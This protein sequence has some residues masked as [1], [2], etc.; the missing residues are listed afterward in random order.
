MPRSIDDDRD[1]LERAREVASGLR[2]TSNLIETLLR[3][4]RENTVS[5]ASLRAELAG[6][7]DNLKV[8]S[9]LVRDSDGQSLM[10]RL[11]L[12]ES[13]SHRRDADDSTSKQNT[14]AIVLAV[15]SGLISL[16]VTMFEVYSK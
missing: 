8:I 5:V 15:L 2:A 9:R 12:L 1:D 16:G 7:S 11:S 3:E 4:V 14:W 10:T 13:D 6:L